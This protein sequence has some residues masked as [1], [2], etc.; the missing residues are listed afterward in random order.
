[1]GEGAYINW[2]LMRHAQCAVACAGR[3]HSVVGGSGGTLHQD[4]FEI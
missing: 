3:V 4:N 2:E 1:M